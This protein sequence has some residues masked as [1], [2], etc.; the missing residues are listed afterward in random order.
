M[1]SDKIH[2]CNDS[3]TY[4]RPVKDSEMFTVVVSKITLFRASAVWVSYV[5]LGSNSFLLVQTCGNH[6]EA[7]ISSLHTPLGRGLTAR[8]FWNHFSVLR[9]YALCN[10]NLSLSHTTRTS[11]QGAL[12]RFPFT[13]WGWLM[14]PFITQMWAQE[15]SHIT[16]ESQKSK[17]L[18]PVLK[19]C[20]LLAS[21]S[22]WLFSADFCTRNCHWSARAARRALGRDGAGGRSLGMGQSLKGPTP[23]TQIRD[24]QR[25]SGNNHRNWVLRFYRL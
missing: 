3:R 6:Y 13:I 1:N 14:D 21:F 18:I 7:P 16:S 4:N 20:C 15:P 25:G 8:V 12:K 17:S 11:A 10:S 2:L 9:L 23:K 19:F 5:C 22:F 24:H